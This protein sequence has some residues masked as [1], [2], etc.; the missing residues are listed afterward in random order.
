[1]VKSILKCGMTL[2]DQPQTSAVEVEQW[3]NFRPTL[4]W[5]YDYLSLLES[6][7]SML[8]GVPDNIYVFVLFIAINYVIIYSDIIE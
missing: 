3:I 5:A 1:M 7:W 4:Y 8:K 2:L 6:S